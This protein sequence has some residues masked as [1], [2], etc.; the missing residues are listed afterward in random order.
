MSGEPYLRCFC[1]DPLTGNALGR[2][3]PKLRNKGH[4]AW[5]FRYEA[6]RGPGGKRRQPEVGPFATKR[7]AEEERA[8]TLTRLAGGGQV[9]DRT[10]TVSSYLTGYA[11]GKLDVKPS[12]RDAIREAIDLYWRPALGHLR[13]V[14]LRDHHI[15]EA[16]AEMMRINRP[17]SADERP[18]D[19]MRR[20]LEARADDERRNLA[21]G[22]SRH[23]K[24]PKPLSP[25]R[26]RRVFAV[27]HA[28]LAT[29]VRTGRIGRNPCDGVSLPRVPRVRPLPWTAAREEVFRVALEKRT[30]EAAAVSELTAIERQRLWAAPDLRPCPVMVWLPQ[31]TGAFLD[32]LEQTR[33]RLFALFALVA[34][35]GLR[36]GEV[37]AL[38]WA[39]V[40]LDQ[41]VAHVRH[42]GDGDTKS[43][44]GTR[45]VPLPAPVVQAVRAWRKQQA[46]DRLAWGPDWYDTDH[47][48]TRE[49]GVPLT[50]Q[51][52]SVRF[53][54]LAFRA[55]LPPVRFHDLRHG[56]ASLAKA[57][58]LDTKYISALLGHSRTSFTDDIYVSLFPEVAAAA[59]EAAAAVVPRK[60]GSAR[61]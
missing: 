30:R 14:D 4:A 29:A 17:L 36:R 13:L 10:L 55:D 45:S 35:C 25:A 48:F 23:K 54:T 2:N 50:G 15:A 47:V 16:V 58:H 49:D 57:A 52:V 6:P 21:P 56:A 33:E 51:W 11:T 31:H 61:D 26:I 3:C 37:I 20:L 44:A 43:D 38:Q 28:A 8:A 5:F 39:E 40:D 46:A 9:Q 24:S 12:T 34:Y 42:A 22:E 19:M 1:R 32:F 27:L 18:S 7:A 53:E 59:A 41:A 60:F